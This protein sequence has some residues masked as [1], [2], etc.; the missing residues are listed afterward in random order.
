[1]HLLEMPDVLDAFVAWASGR[2][3]NRLRPLVLQDQRLFNRALRMAGWSH[4]LGG[5]IKEVANSMDSW[6]YFLQQMRALCWSF[7]NKTYRNHITTSC[8]VAEFPI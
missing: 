5:V 1:M 3:L 7:R 8:G 6:P 2:P 4:T